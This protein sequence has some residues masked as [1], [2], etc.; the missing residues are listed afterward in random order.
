[1]D[2]LNILGEA[3]IPTIPKTW[4]NWISILREKYRKTETFQIYV[5]LIYFG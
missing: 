5:F 4:G 2:F 3:E 1:M